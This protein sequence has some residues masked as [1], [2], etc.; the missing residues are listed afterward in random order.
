[1][2]VHRIQKH[3]VYGIIFTFINSLYNYYQLSDVLSGNIY[4]STHIT[5]F[6]H[7]SL[8]IARLKDCN[9]YKVY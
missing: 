6:P 4:H 8:Q 3:Q 2:L 1:M 7:S 5:E 9:N